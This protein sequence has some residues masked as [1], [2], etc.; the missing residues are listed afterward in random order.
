MWLELLLQDDA[1]NQTEEDDIEI[2]DFL[3]PRFLIVVHDFPY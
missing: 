2:D 3:Y 1:E